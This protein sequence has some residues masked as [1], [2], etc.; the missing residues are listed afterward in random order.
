MAYNNDYNII[1]HKTILLEYY[2]E[3]LKKFVCEMRGGYENSIINGNNIQKEYVADSRAVLSEGVEGL[4]LSLFPHFDDKMRKNYEK[5]TKNEEDIYKKY[6]TN[7]F[8]S[9]DTENS[10][11][12]IKKLKLSKELFK[13]LSCLL[14]RLGYL[15]NKSS[16]ELMDEADEEL[17]DDEVDIK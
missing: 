1:S 9:G 16:D 10:S 6:S 17:G 4:A 11:Y 3:V 15:K 5:Y 8:I 14:C 12:S 13:D 2:Q 7:G